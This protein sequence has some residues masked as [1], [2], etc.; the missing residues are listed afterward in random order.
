MTLC[1]PENILSHTAKGSFLKNVDNPDKVNC[2]SESP[3]GCVNGT[4]SGAPLEFLIP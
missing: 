3:R 2:R 1:I 4:E